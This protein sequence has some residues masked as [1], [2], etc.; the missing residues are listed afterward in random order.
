MT[1]MADRIEQVRRTGLKSRLVNGARVLGNYWRRGV[2]CSAG[3]SMKCPCGDGATEFCGAK[4]KWVD[5]LRDHHGDVWPYGLEG[6]EPFFVID[7]M[8]RSMSEA[9]GLTIKIEYPGHP[10][11]LVGPKGTDWRTI[12]QLSEIQDTPDFSDAMEAVLMIQT[13][14]L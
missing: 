5:I 8:S 1:D 3:W 4:V 12:G 10:P 9:S 14:G 6:T 7:A 11:I 13:V 2:R